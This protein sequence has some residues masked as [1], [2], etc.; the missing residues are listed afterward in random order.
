MER[1]LKL[2]GIYFWLNSDSLPVLK[3][4][5]IRFSI[6]KRLETVSYESVDNYKRLTLG[7]VTIIYRG[8]PQ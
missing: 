4:G 7:Y 5:R 8:V 3:I 1:C 6:R 2:I